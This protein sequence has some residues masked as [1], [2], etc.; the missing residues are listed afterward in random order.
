MEP[1]KWRLGERLFPST[2]LIFRK[3]V[4]HR[5][6][7]CKICV[8]YRTK[9]AGIGNEVSSRGSGDADAL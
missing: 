2:P 4:K 6:Q 8:L 3:N 1:T 7:F 5:K 9:K